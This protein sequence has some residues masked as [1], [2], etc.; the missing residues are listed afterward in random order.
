MAASAWTQRDA[1]SA[2]RAT[3][4]VG[5]SQ[6]QQPELP[7]S[8]RDSRL[9]AKIRGE[10]TGGGPGTDID[11]LTATAR[12]GNDGSGTGA[13]VADAEPVA[14]ECGAKTDC[15]RAP[16][17]AAE[18]ARGLSSQRLELC[19]AGGSHRAAGEGGTVADCGGDDGAGG[20]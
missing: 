13:D 7:C 11:F 20:G 4:A 6:R 15:R 1:D 16:G 2:R 14:I 9:L 18:I 10:G 8:D 19:G 12:R 3:R 17:Q 5:G